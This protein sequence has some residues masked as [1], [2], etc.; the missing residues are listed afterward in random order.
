MGFSLKI[1]KYHEELENLKTQNFKRKKKKKI[2]EKQTSKTCRFAKKF[3]KTK[4]YFHSI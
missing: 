3:L 2:R 4:P 1:C